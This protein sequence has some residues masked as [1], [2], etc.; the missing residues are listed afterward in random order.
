MKVVSLQYGNYNICARRLCVGLQFIFVL[1]NADSSIEG[2]REQ[3]ASSIHLPFV[4]FAVRPT[5]QTKI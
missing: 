2:A 1:L 4:N 3:F 5:A